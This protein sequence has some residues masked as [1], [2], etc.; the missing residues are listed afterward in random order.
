MFP[1]PIHMRPLT[2]VVALLLV[3]CGKDAEPGEAAP[4]DTAAK[5]D[6]TPEVAPLT[7]DE[8]A[9]LYLSSKDRINAVA[10]LPADGL[11]SITADLERVANEA[12]D[13]HLR[14]NAS[15]LLG[16]LHDE[17]GDTRA[18][19]SYY[20]QAKELVPDD[21]ST[22]AVLAFALAEA[23]RW[24]DAIAEQYIVVELVPDDLEA[25]LILGELHVK[26][27]KM[28]EAP[29]VYAAYELRRHGLL[30]GLTQKR[31]GEYVKDEDHRAGC[32]AA[33]MPAADNGTAVGL[34]W[35]LESDPSPV[36]RAQVAGV[37]GEQR[38]AGYL[39]H[40][41]KKL[42]NET[43]ED[44]REAMKWAIAEIERDPIDTTPGAVPDAIRE[45]VEAR[46][47]QLAAELAEKAGEAGEAEKAGDAGE[48]GEAEPEG[49]PAED[50]PTEAADSP[51]D[52]G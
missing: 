22:H 35:A 10:Q 21:P 45:E 18:A 17:R 40:L 29:Q 13:A 44:V 23:G 49:A 39:D 28:D 20:R 4:V 47:K 19:L 41:R 15:L 26:G 36:V 2:L 34:M 11:E 24:D 46:E 31:D 8:L 52:P 48:A 14:A 5:P 27:G 32:A 30:E 3:A 33:L 16:S 38:L 1:R 25:W 9:E 7:Q 6:P 51:A 12:E 42:A 50:A 37:M 43:D